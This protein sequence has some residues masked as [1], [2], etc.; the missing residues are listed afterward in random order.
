MLRDR[1]AT[2]LHHLGIDRSNYKVLKLLPLI[3][4]AWAKGEVEPA[5]KERIVKLAHDHF[6]IGTRGE[7]VLRGWLEKKPTKEYFMKG[8]HEIFLLAHTPD[9][10]G[11][12]VDELQGL[13]AHSEAIART[14]AAAMD[15]PTAVTAAEE[16][17]LADIGRELQVD[18]GETWAKLMAELGEGR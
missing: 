3:Y 9:E 12:D 13:L 16:A 18:D 6:A 11:F 2:A 15:Q 1:Q 8:L 10:W 7:Q 17:A 14:T 4:V 5:R